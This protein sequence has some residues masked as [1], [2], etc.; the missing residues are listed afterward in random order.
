M[1]NQN[2]YRDLCSVKKNI[3]LHL[4]PW[5]L[6]AAYG[7]DW[8]VLL[9]ETNPEYAAL[10]YCIRKTK[11][12]KTI[13]PPPLSP[14]NGCWLDL[15]QD[16]SGYD[17]WQLENTILTSFARQIDALH[18]D[19]FLH[20]F[21]PAI[22]NW[23]P[24]Y[25]QGFSQTTRY[26]YT[27]ENLQDS[28]LVWNGFQKR[29]RRYIRSLEKRMTVVPATAEDIFQLSEPTYKRQSMRPPYTEKY[30]RQLFHA[31]EQNRVSRAIK[32][33]DENGKPVGI[34]WMVWDNGKAYGVILGHVENSPTGTSQLMLWDQF[35]FAAQQGIP[36]YD[37]QGSMM[38]KVALFN[39]RMGA[40]PVPYFCIEKY[41]SRGYRLLR[42]LRQSFGK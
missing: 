26:T 14:L 39:H 25:W 35:R 18:A 42:T 38:E 21:S 5:W 31:A 28:D 1:N 37:C 2:I 33:L 34:H 17:A 19:F 4:Q 13:V 8:D 22:T 36:R 29:V 41:Y 7:S 32:L 27:I 40:E 3:P 30:I 15:P 20:Y 9:A 10:P 16:L 6:D 24:F 12:F 23:Q 11:G